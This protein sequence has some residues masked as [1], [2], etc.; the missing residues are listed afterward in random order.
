MT[1][2]GLLKKL[3]ANEAGAE[4]DDTK[5]SQSF[6]AKDFAL[7]WLAVNKRRDHLDL[8]DRLA[9]DGFLNLF[10]KVRTLFDTI[11]NSNLFAK[12]ENA[13]NIFVNTFLID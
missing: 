13:K 5:T 2:I 6:S 4:Y 11:P 7:I 1:L 12:V 8:S 9:N 3:T 10:R